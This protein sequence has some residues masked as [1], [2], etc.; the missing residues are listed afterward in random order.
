[1]WHFL[2]LIV[3]SILSAIAAP[4]NAPTSPMNLYINDIN[5]RPDSKP[6]ISETNRTM[7]PII[8]ANEFKFNVV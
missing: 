8:V 2:P 7:V 5:V 3:A 4:A 6:Y 1:M